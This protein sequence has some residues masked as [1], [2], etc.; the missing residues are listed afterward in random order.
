[1]EAGLHTISWGLQRMG[2]ALGILV[3]GALFAYVIW[4]VVIVAGQAV[5]GWGH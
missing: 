2:I 5:A 1:M 3:F 4:V